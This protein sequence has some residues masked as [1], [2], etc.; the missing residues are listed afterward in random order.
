MT[1]NVQ[2]AYMVSRH[3]EIRSV[4]LVAASVETSFDPVRPPDELRL[5][6]RYRANHDLREKHP[7]HVFI[8]ID[9]EFEGFE[10]DDDGPR[11]LFLKASY[12]IV[13]DLEDAATYPED[14]LEHFAELNGPYNAWPY[15]R[16]LVQTVTGRVGV[17]STVI[18]V[19]RPET[20]VLEE[21]PEAEKEEV[22]PANADLVQ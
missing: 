3:V 16:E 22:S 5:V 10:A 18:P 6:Q 20:K 21:E 11:V 9:L 19:F 2:R 8:R 1:T 13:Y 7:D 15:W 14:A 17:D 4:G 12:Q